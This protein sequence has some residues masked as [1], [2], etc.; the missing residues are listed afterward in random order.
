MF[1]DWAL[2]RG[3]LID[4]RTEGRG[5]TMVFDKGK[6]ALSVSTLDFIGEAVAQALL[7]RDEVLNRFLYVHSAAV[8]QKQLLEYVR[9]LAPDLKIETVAL[10]TAKLEEQALEKLRNGEGGPEVNTTLLLRTSF[11]LGLGLF[12]R[13]DNALLGLDTWKEEDVKTLVAKYVQ[14]IE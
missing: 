9:E 10:N 4:V 7:K 2:G 8:T 14:R 3:F 1:F 11:G 6:T 12:E 5:P 13:T